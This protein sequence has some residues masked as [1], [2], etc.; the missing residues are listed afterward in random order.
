[1]YTLFGRLRRIGS[2]CNRSEMNVALM[3]CAQRSVFSRRLAAIANATDS[4]AGTDS[5]TQ[6]SS[7]LARRKAVGWNTMLDGARC[8]TFE[9]SGLSRTID[10]NEVSAQVC[11]LD[12]RIM[13]ALS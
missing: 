10:P 1:M 12:H 4:Q 9:V 11:L 6:K 8:R 7:D 2:S 13:D 3:A 5:K